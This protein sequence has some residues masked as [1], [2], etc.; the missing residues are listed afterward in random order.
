MKVFLSEYRHDYTTYTFGYTIY[1]T[2]DSP[3]DLDKL[4]PEGFLPYTGNPELK[5]ELYYKSRG[6]RIDLA[7]FADSSENRRVHRKAEDLHIEYQITP[8]GQFEQWDQFYAFAKQYSEER[9]GEDKMPLQRIAYISQRKYL[10]H[11]LSFT[12]RGT[13]IGYI[14]AIITNELF[15][16]WFAFYDTVT[17]EQGIPLGKWLMWKCI[18]IAKD[19][20]KQHIYL[21]NGYLEKSLYKTRDFKAV[22]YFDG[23]VWS[24]Q[25]KDLQRLCTSD[26]ELKLIDEFKQLQNPDDWLSKLS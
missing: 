8:V 24:S 14:L 6:I 13:V 4:Y 26:K 15:H 12:S 2:Y 21:G 20:G 5:H 11:V 18:H 22:E 9:I 7:K 17:L 25:I 1:A 3:G 10:T 19:S 16:Y 23:N